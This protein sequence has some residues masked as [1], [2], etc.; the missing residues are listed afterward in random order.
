[1]NRNPVRCS[2]LTIPQGTEPQSAPTADFRAW[3][4]PTITIIDLKRTMLGTGPYFDGL[5][6][7]N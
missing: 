3:H 6:T 1:M 4:S 5:A 2:E 7:S